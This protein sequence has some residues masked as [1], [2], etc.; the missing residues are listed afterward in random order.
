MA[1]VGLPLQRERHVLERLADRSCSLLPLSSS[2]PLTS[3]PVSFPL[4][5]P[6]TQPTDAVDAFVPNLFLHTSLPHLL[7]LTRVEPRSVSQDN[8][9]TSSILDVSNRLD[10]YN[11]Y[12]ETLGRDRNLSF[13][14]VPQAFGKEAYWAE[15]PTGEGE[16]SRRVF[17]LVFSSSF[18]C[19]SFRRKEEHLTKLGF[20]LGVF[21]WDE[22][23]SSS[24][25]C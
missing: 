24:A 3:L 22:Q 10:A 15:V 1:L 25:R 7:K 16:F 11:G 20:A 5:S 8:C 9:F 6:A 14:A 21:R 4:P 17:V 2:Y 18:S 23:K 19:G 12:R 13:W